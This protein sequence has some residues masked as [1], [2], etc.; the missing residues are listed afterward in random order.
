MHHHSVLWKSQNSFA[1]KCQDPTLYHIQ[2]NTYQ[3]DQ[4]HW[5]I[6]N[7]TVQGSRTGGEKNLCLDWSSIST[8]ISYQRKS[9]SFTKANSY[10]AVGTTSQEFISLDWLSRTSPLHFPICPQNSFLFK[11]HVRISLQIA[12]HGVW[13]K[14][15]CTVAVAGIN[16]AP[17]YF[18]CLAFLLERK[19]YE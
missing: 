19:S 14:G 9:F 5:N 15:K 11:K 2:G 8:C 1:K 7:Y 18:K 17:W 10:T 3:A 13:S 6:Q 4:H 12:M 16:V